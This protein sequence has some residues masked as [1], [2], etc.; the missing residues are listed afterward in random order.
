MKTYFQLY[1]E[2]NREK[3]KA[4]TKAYYEKN[5]EKCLETSKRWAK[6]NKEK[7]RLASK[8]WASKDY[9]NN[10]TKYEEYRKTDIVKQAR[11][12][13][14]DSH[15]EKCNKAVAKR[16]KERIK[17]DSLYKLTCLLRAR[18]HGA[19]RYNLSSKVAKSF[20]LLGCTAKEAKEYLEKMFK[21]D[22]N[23]E[24]HG[25]L[26][27]IDH[28]IPIASF[29]LSKESEQRKAFNYKNL[30]PLYKIENRKKGSRVVI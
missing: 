12:R 26:W 15:K 17:T 11:K 29:D 7:V 30:Q 18:L 1:Y 4:Q 2:K 14:Y 5:K 24:N 20:S 28:I 21:S 6:N 23:W 8:E 16:N 13:Y 22:M 19:F 10:P 25:I 27:E 3:R 9:A